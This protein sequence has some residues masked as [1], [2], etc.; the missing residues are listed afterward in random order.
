[1]IDA[2]G[3]GL[4]NL[5]DSPISVHMD[6]AGNIY[7]F[8]QLSGRNLFKI[9]PGGTITKIADESGDGMGNV[10]LSANDIES[11][12]AGNLYLTSQGFDANVFMLSPSLVFTLL[13]N[14]TGDG[15][16]PLRAPVHIALTSAGTLYA[17]GSHSNNVFERLPNGT[18]TQIIGSGLNIAYDLVLDSAENLYIG[19]PG[20]GQVFRRT[21]GGSL[22]VVLDA[23]MIPGGGTFAPWSL[24][25]DSN[26]T[27]FVESRQSIVSRTSGGV[28]TRIPVPGAV[29]LAG[30]AVD[31][32]DN[33]YTVDH[34]GH[35]AYRITFGPVSTTT[36]T[37]T[38]T[39]TS[40][41]GATS[42]TSTSSSTS[43]TTFTTL[44][45][46]RMNGCRK[47]TIEFK[48]RFQLRNKIGNS[49][50]SFNWKWVKGE[51]T[52]LADFGNPLATE[53]Y[54]LC[55]VDAFNDRHFAVTIPPGGVC[56]DRPCWKDN[57]AVGFKYT[58][59]AGSQGG[60]QKVILKSGG[61]GLAMVVVKGKGAGLDVPNLPLPT[62][63][64][65]QLQASS[66]TCWE[67]EFRT[68]GVLK[69]GPDQFSVKASIPVRSPSGA[70]VD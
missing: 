32:F 60:I 31:G 33:V 53:S 46:C 37:T 10:L 61:E 9:T 1:V 48:G 11:D 26:D 57:G 41:F 36:S 25:V 54:T 4:G 23:S 45:L 67:A 16:H 22:S 63:I 51:E 68:E 27:L 49:G 5:Y 17:A 19:S 52:V 64:L 66:G 30:V 56:N 7:T 62:P 3:D 39:S 50:D 70:F 38:T 2:S 29:Y 13:M 21:P 55:V 34:E 15:V 43:S 69:A 40:L 35:R 58:D 18:I 47:P 59:K 12:P 8:G 20:S 24:A 14:N 28:V 42:T 44:P 65:V 6:A